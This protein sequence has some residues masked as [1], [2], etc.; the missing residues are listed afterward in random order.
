[1][2]WKQASDERLYLNREVGGTGLKLMPDVYKETRPRVAYLMSK[3]EN[4]W[5]QAAERKKTLKVENAV[6]T[7]AQTTT[8]EMQL[9]IEE[10]AMQLDG[11]RIKQERKP[12]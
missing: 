2:L 5:T 11:E 10:N 4:K 6:V 8:E 3:S 1:M 9:K 12:T 7:E